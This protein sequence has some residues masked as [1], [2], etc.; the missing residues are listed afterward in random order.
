M[1]DI[2]IALRNLMRNRVRSA[3]SLLAI[4]FGVVALL[5][6]GGFIEWI[7]HDLRETTILSRLGH[8]QIT[9]TGFFSEGVADPFAFVLPENAKQIDAIARVPEVRLVTPRLSF[10]GLISHGQTTISFLGEGV[11]PEKEVIVSQH[12]TIS[13]GENLSTQD[14]KGIVLGEGLAANLEVKPGDKVVLLATT[15]SGGINAVE[16][17]VRG[18]FYTTSKAFD[19]T[20]L[21]LPIDTARELLRVTGSHTWVLLLRKTE[22]TDSALKK[23]K[24]SLTEGKTPLEVTSWTAQADFYHKTVKLFSRQFGVVKF[25]IGL[26]IVL[27]IS[28]TMT[29]SVLER[30][31]E[32][33][34]L[35]AMGNKRKKILQLFVT[36]GFLLGVMG[37]LIGLLLGIVLAKVISL[38][39]IPMPPAPG[40]TRGFTGQI[41]VTSGLASSAF[42][43]AS[44][45]SVLASLYPSW[46]AS[47]LQIVD[48]LRH[49]R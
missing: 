42:L 37:G 18:I 1:A 40:M 44:F 26:I 12:V 49:N 35:M 30:T 6:S 22:D 33:G 11:D 25:I 28:N 34:T 29:M 41:L 31:G 9:R 10:A 20:F 3:V 23:I 21:R 48:A 16:T 45:T 5:L 17:I 13:Q 32:I 7:F 27:S 15:E 46:K 19:D 4:V 8:L 36:E 47:Q 43:I 2:V 39:G 38:I 24:K 14:R